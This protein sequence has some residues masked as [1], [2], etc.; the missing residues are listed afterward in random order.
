MLL[1]A[2]PP[3]PHTNPYGKNMYASIQSQTFSDIFGCCRT[4]GGWGPSQPLIG[5]HPK[6][7]VRIQGLKFI[8][9]LFVSSYTLIP[10]HETG[11]APPVRS[12]THAGASSV[13]SK[14]GGY[15]T[16]PSLVIMAALLPA[17]AIK[18]R[19]SQPKRFRY[20]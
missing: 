8:E 6:M 11:R 19:H 15:C 16:R 2:G 9:H 4:A 18:E 17:V 10:R 3:P 5:L 13:V 12:P 14:I 7:S 1:Q 20:P